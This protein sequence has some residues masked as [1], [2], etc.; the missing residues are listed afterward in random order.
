MLMHLKLHPTFVPY[1]CSNILEI[2]DQNNECFKDVSKT[3][4]DGWS[5]D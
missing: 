3:S 1:N 4:Q 2:H 5:S